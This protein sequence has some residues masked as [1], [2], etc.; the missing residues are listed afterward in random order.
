MKIKGMLEVSGVNL[1][2]NIEAPDQ[3]REIYVT[4]VSP[5]CLIIPRERFDVGYLGLSYPVLEE[6]GRKK[7]DNLAQ[8]L[9]IGWELD[10]VALDL[11]PR[12]KAELEDAMAKFRKMV[13]MTEFAEE[14]KSVAEGPT[15]AL[16]GLERSKDTG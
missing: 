12:A 13:L 8:L 1:N 3:S 14:S 4:N 7:I 6:L 9:P 2:V 10:W 5:Q 15:D 16:Q 11:T